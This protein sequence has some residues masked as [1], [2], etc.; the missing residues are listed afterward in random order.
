[1][2]AKQPWEASEV[3][4]WT[5]VLLMMVT[6][7][8]SSVGASKGLKW[9]YTWTGS[10]SLKAVGKVCFDLSGVIIGSGWCLAGNFDE[11]LLTL[12][13]VKTTKERRQ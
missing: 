1:M 11:I 12:N 5:L 9:Q 2:P 7:E 4:T 10:I 3:M 8:S 6:Q 13:N